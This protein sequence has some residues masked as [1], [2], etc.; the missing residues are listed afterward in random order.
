MSAGNSSHSQSVCTTN[1]QHQVV[2][3]SVADVAT[4]VRAGADLRR[5]ST[6]DLKGAGLKELR[7]VANHGCAFKMGVRNLWSHLTPPGEKTPEHEVFLESTTNFAHVDQRF[8]GVLTQPTV[9][10]QPCRPLRF[11]DENFA[12]GWLVVRSDG[13]IQRQTL[14]PSTMQWELA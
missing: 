11:V 14:D 4:A 2:E 9:L 1:R 13:K 3:G 5:F 7:R 12:A 6:Y 10:L 8:F